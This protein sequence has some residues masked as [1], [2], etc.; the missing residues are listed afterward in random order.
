MCLSW[1]EKTGDPGHCPKGQ[2]GEKEAHAAIYG[3]S[4][5]I[6]EEEVLLLQNESIALA[7]NK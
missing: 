5:L 1:I 3:G 7:N 2:F 4:M 6:I